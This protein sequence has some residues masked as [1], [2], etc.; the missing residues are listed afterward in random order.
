MLPP[1]GDP[2]ILGGSINTSALLSISL[3]TGVRII[4]G[5]YY[6][7][8]SAFV[9]VPIIPD[10]QWLVVTMIIDQDLPLVINQH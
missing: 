8:L 6:V 9:I 10:E 7:D 5:D 3:T 1:P 4:N 2:K